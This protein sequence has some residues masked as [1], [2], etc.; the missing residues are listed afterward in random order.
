MGSS[1]LSALPSDDSSSA[2]L[3]VTWCGTKSASELPIKTD[4]NARRAGSHGLI[5]ISSEPNKEPAPLPKNRAASRRKKFVALPGRHCLFRASHRYDI[6]AEGSHLDRSGV[7]SEMR[8]YTT[9][10]T[11]LAPPPM[12]RKRAWAQTSRNGKI[13]ENQPVKLQDSGRAKKE[14][15]PSART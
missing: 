8:T 6:W 12:N 7:T 9:D 2:S 15:T 14:V 11:T 1:V 13:S 4:S 3:R 5:C 10:S